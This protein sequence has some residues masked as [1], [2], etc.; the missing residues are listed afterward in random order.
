MVLGSICYLGDGSWQSFRL[1]GVDVKGEQHDLMCS[2]VVT[3]VYY[4]PETKPVDTQYIIPTHNEICIYDTTFY[5]G[6]EIIHPILQ[7][8]ASAK[9]AYNEAK[10]AGKSA[11][12]GLNLPNGLSKFKIG[13]VPPQSEIKIEVKCA[14]VASSPDC[15]SVLTQFPLRAASQNGE[16]DL[17]SIL[18]NETLNAFKM[19][20]EFSS[21]NPLTTYESNYESGQWEKL[22]DNKIRFSLD[23]PFGDSSLSFKFGLA[24]PLS[25]N[26]LVF[27][28]NNTRHVGLTVV[29]S[30]EAEYNSDFVFLVDCSGSMSG[31]SIRSAAECLKLF[32]RSLPDGCSFEIVK[33]GSSFQNAFGSLVEYNE[34]NFATAMRI[35]EGL[36]ADLGGTEILPPLQNIFS[37]K[38]RKGRVTQLFLLTDGEVENKDSVL[39]LAAK[40][41]KTHRIFAVGIGTSVD[42]SLVYGVSRA[43]NGEAAIAQEVSN[44]ANVVMPLL[45]SSLRSCI[46]NVQIE[47]EGSSSVQ[48]SPFPIPNLFN[49]AAEVIFLKDKHLRNGPV[50]L[51]GSV[52]ESKYEEVVSQFAEI[53][54]PLPKVL[55]A[56]NCIRDLQNKIDLGENVS[57]NIEAIIQLSIESGII[58]EHTAYIGISEKQATE[59]PKEKGGFFSSIKRLFSSKPSNISVPF[60]EEEIVSYRYDMECCKCAPSA[61]PQ[62]MFACDDMDEQMAECMEELSDSMSSNIAPMECEEL[63]MKEQEFAPPAPIQQQM[64]SISPSI[65]QKCEVSRRS[66]STSGGMSNIVDLAEFGGYWKDPNQI[67]SANGVNLPPIPGELAALSDKQNEAFASVIALALLRKGFLNDKAKWN[68]IEKKCMKFLSGLSS[69]IDW[70]KMINELVQ[71]L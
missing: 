71:V 43:T 19:S 25:S 12:L 16:I 56:Y 37:W 48:I 30:I 6:D 64:R 49:K 3:Q 55:F 31:S 57:R 46:S 53:E 29:P 15:N 20:Y 66:G 39:S 18:E 67:C 51:T 61:A 40:H 27:N 41:R 69:S 54:N 52:S 7:D 44:L 42:K 23:S 1:R 14:Y 38:Q 58:I 60:V 9:Q 68:L 50:L 45:E 22:Q 2:F 33:F 28:D 59:Q 63:C 8:V 36:D 47:I 21:I 34:Q 35:A 13:N 10:S 4:N 17:K 24:N 70:E 65:I 26:G 62:M 11:V 5:V 32:L